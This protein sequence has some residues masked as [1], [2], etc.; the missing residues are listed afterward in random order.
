MRK[1]ES[2]LNA[3][4][5]MAGS[6]YLPALLMQ[7]SAF[8]LKPGPVVIEISDRGTLIVRQAGAD[9][10]KSDPAKSRNKVRKRK[11]P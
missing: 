7:D 6:V 8:P 5:K 9:C 4:G 2:K 11:A 1:V 10:P 3:M